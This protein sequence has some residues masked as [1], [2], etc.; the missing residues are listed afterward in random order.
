VDLIATLEHSILFW[1]IYMLPTIV[2]WFRN[3]KPL[4]P[5]FLLNLLGG[6]TILVWFFMWVMVFPS[7]FQ[8]LVGVFAGGQAFKSGPVGYTGANHGE[9]PQQKKCT[10]CNEGR[11]TCPMCHGQPNRYEQPQGENGTPILVQCHYCL[12]SGTVQCLTC[13]GTGYVW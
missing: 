4:G 12:G 9:T 8:A 1:P 3:T 13:G 11:M 10:Q 2:A 7:V 6:W 5:I